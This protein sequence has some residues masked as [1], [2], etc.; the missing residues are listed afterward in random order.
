MPKEAMFPGG[1]RRV[2]YRLSAGLTPDDVEFI[3]AE[4]PEAGMISPS[5]DA[6][7]D[8]AAPHVM[9][10]ARA[11][12][13]TFTLVATHIATGDTLDVEVAPHGAEVFLLDAPVSDP[14]LAARL[15]ALSAASRRRTSAPPASAAASR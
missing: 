4:G 6:R 8:D 5:R 10:L 3:V 11:R 7:W 9:L 14:A 1:Y 13:G 15:D 12:T 2:P